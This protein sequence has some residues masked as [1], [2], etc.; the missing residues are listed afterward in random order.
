MEVFKSLLK[1]GSVYVR[2]AVISGH[3]FV[4]NIFLQL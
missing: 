3:S 2:D 4:R 1:Q